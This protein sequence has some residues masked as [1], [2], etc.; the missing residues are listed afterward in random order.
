M[1]RRPWDRALGERCPRPLAT[2]QP[3]TRS[4]FEG[5]MGLV[6]IKRRSRSPGLVLGSWQA[7]AAEVPN[8]QLGVSR[9][10][11]TGAG[12]EA[13]GGPRAPLGAQGPPTEPRRK[14]PREAGQ[15]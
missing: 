5:V 3:G 11:E 9:R 13:R 8:L 4:A 7:G 14:E 6:R 15:G 12:P 1:A 10:K 2:L